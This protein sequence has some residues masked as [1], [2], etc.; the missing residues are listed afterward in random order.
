MFNPIEIDPEMYSGFFLLHLN[1]HEVDE[2]YLWQMTQFLMESEKQSL[3]D[4]VNAFELQGTSDLLRF[5]EE[6]TDLEEGEQ[7]STSRLIHS[8]SSEELFDLEMRAKKTDWPPLRSLLT[9][10]R[11]DLRGLGGW[12]AILKYYTE[13]K[14]DEVDFLYPEL[15]ASPA[16][17]TPSNNPMFG[18]QGYLQAAPQGIDA[19]HMWDN[20]VF[21]TGV[22]FMDLEAGWDL[23]HTEFF[24]KGIVVHSG[25]N[26]IAPNLQKHGTAVLGITIGDDNGTD[27]VGIAPMKNLAQPNNKVRVVSHWREYPQNP[28]DIL[29]NQVADAILA[30]FRDMDFGDVLL[31]EVAWGLAEWPAEKQVDVR[32]AIRLAV[33]VGEIIVVEAAGNGSYDLNGYKTFPKGE[34]IFQRNHPDSEDSGAIMVGASES[35]SLHNWLP[36][37]NYGSRINCFAWGEDVF[38]TGYSPNVKGFGGTSAAAAIIAGAAILLQSRYES[39]YSGQRLSPEKMRYYLSTFGTEQGPVHFD[40]KIGIMPNLAAIDA[41]L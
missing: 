3:Y 41:K 26:Q 24:G 9:Y 5:M 4:L 29:D 39:L 37:S 36:T 7:L 8:Y 12:R 14:L 38:T 32:D 13:S 18:N 30:A 6:V 16:N 22:G 1:D 35:D 27:G 20:D 28:D 2:E 15:I 33:G 23:N 34:Y 17:F 21:G 40:R 25:E 19:K 10:W 31:I 11:I